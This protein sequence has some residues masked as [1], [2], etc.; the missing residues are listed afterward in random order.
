[1]GGLQLSATTLLAKRRHL[2]PGFVG[3]LDRATFYLRGV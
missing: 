2:F 3:D 1:M